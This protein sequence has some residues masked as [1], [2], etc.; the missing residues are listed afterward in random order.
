MPIYDI[1]LIL[2]LCAALAAAAPAGAQDKANEEGGNRPSV[3]SASKKVAADK[4][5]LDEAIG[6]AL[7]QS[8]RLQAFRS[9]VAAAK[10]ERRQAGARQ[11]PEVSFSKENFRAGAAYKVI[12]PAQN[13]YGVSQLVEIGGKISARQDV[14]D[15][16]V[17]IAGLEH[18]AAALDLIRDVTV[19]Y[20][21]A[22][23]AEQSVRLAG[24]Q[25]ALAEDVL[26]S[27]STRVDAAAAPLIQKARADVEREAASVAL[28]TAKRRRDITRKR[29]AVLLGE[30]KDNF[31]IDGES[32]FALSKPD[33]E[34]AVEKL[35][36]GPD[37][38]RLNSLEEQARSRYDLERANAI[39][40]PRISAGLTRIPS[41]KDQALLVG[42]SLPIPVLNANRG[43]IERAR[44]EVSR[45]EQENRN[46]SLSLAADLNTAEQLLENAYLQ[47]S[48][49]KN[50]ILP[51]A[52]KAFALAREGYELGRFP[53]LEV[54]DA[55]R[56]L[57]EVKQQHIA[58]LKDYH[59]ARAIVER[60]T[61][62]HLPKLTTTGETDGE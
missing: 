13:V 7:A 8:P 47:A 39:P 12:S 3:E 36:S 62:A 29:L 23:A 40:D 50:K 61:A 27:V 21:E 54:L 43:N 1:Y 35:T 49:F 46:A 15:K 20:A 55:Q 32:F 11:N 57:F 22:V 31:A 5:T 26:K 41:A 9:A 52:Q 60:L 51:S 24:E 30:D 28:D 4:L 33:E 10:A 17:E 16:G 6:R 18:Q 59:T 56:R 34:A 14:A 44:T 58:A 45:T 37:M 19:A 42:V 25:K 48:T 2:P 53:Y 38:L